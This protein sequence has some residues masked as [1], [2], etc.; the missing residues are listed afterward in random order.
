[1]MKMIEVT[2]NYSVK[3]LVEI[4]NKLGLL[5]EKLEEG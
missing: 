5:R 4:S 1:M 2:E 3:L